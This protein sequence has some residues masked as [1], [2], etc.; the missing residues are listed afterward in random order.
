MVKNPLP[1][2]ELQEP[3]LQSLDGKDALEEETG[4]PL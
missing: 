2:Q 1:M 3:R 4:N